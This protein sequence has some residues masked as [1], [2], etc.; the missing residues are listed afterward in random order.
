MANA[1]IV[2]TQQQRPQGLPGRSR[3]DL[4]IRIPVVVSNHD[5]IG[6]ESWTWTL[7]SPVGSKV[8]LRS[9]KSPIATFTPDVS[10]SYEIHLVIVSSGITIS[11]QRTA[12]I[13]TPFLGLK[14]PFVSKREDLISDPW[15][16]VGESFDQLDDDASKNLKKDGSN[17][18]TADFSWGGHKII[19]LG[20]LELE[21]VLR[22]GK[23]E[24]PEAINGKGFLYLRDIGRST[25][26]FYCGSDGALVRLTKDGRLNIPASFD[27]KIK[28]QSDDENPDYLSA[29]LEAG[30]GLSKQIVDG[31]LQ[32]VPV[33]GSEPG[34]I[35]AGNDPRLIKPKDEGLQG[36][37][38]EI[39]TTKPTSHTI[40]IS[41]EAGKLD[42]WV[43]E[44]TKGSKGIIRLGGD[45]AGSAQEPKVIALRGLSIP[46]V[47]KD[48]FLKWNPNGTGIEV[49]SYG[50]SRGTVCCGDDARLSDPR[51][52]N[53]EAGGQ[54]TGS[55][56]N[57]KVVGLTDSDNNILKLG[58]ISDG[59]A[60]VRQGDYI[61]GVDISSRRTIAMVINE[62]TDSQDDVLVGCF[63]LDGGKNS[64]P[65]SFLAISKVSRSG[66]SGIVKFHNATDNYLITQINV[67][68]LTLASK[69]V[70]NIH[71]PAGKKLYEVY[72]SLTNGNMGAD[73]ITCM[74]AG[75]LD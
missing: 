12:I 21:G 62:H 15:L 72:I 38:E 3:S 46:E 44:A 54:L 29:K 11:D 28:L 22:L 49:A 58:Q 1:A 53:G 48:A 43:S 26:L 24:D 64:T 10:G 73:N 31:I 27:D 35:C 63:M 60:L 33:F 39:A 5:N 20:G 57:P 67:V 69:R 52:P 74:W 34:T 41:N 32:F 51:T 37:E 65:I 55:F 8:V 7:L 50:I 42:D 19:D 71:L 25:D 30:T 66:L 18:P 6:V 16:A 13:G 40:P 17:I 68:E 2:I 56:P 59:T 47:T 45:L 70:C 23:A 14:K 61:T 75:L 36:R 9:S 4:L